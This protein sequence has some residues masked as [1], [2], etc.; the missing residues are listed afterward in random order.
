MENERSEAVIV[1]YEN[2]GFA[3]PISRN[4]L[5]EA[6]LLSAERPERDTQLAEEIQLGSPIKIGRRR[7]GYG[8]GSVVKNTAC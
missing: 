6:G 5:A 8:R 1:C 3:G 7:L 2:G 4:F